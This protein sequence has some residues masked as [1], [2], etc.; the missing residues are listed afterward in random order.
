MIGASVDT[1]ERNEEFRAAEGLE[2][3]V[4]SDPTT[5][6]AGELGL[7]EEIKGYGLR[8]ART[9]YLLDADGTIRRIWRVGRTDS[10]DEHPGEVLAAVRPEAA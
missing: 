1:S 3:E 7:L 2:Y 10:L 8:S 6:L 5:E 4:L 9:T